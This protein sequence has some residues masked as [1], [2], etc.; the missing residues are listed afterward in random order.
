MFTKALRRR[1]SAL[2]TV[3]GLGL[4]LPFTFGATPAYAQ[5]EL[6]VTKTHSG[7]FARNGQGVYH[8]EVINSGTEATTGRTL[9]TDNLPSGLTLDHLDVTTDEPLPLVCV[10]TNNDTGFV[11]E[12]VLPLG[13]GE[14][15]TVDATVNIA[16]DAPCTVTNTATLSGVDEPLLDSASDPTTIT[17]GSCDNSGGSILPINLSGIIPVYNNINTNSNVLSPAATNTNTQTFGI[18]AP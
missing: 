17:G 7:N 4:A 18:N 5:A 16:G 10:P 13:P 6:S 9:L 14:G 2:G 8:I 15:Y 1:T 12:T 11:C 3:L